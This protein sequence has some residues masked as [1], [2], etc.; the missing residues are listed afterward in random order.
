MRVLLAAAVLLGPAVALAQPDDR[1]PS[2]TPRVFESRGTIEV[3]LPDLERQPLSGFG[4]PPRTFVVPADRRPV[5][6]PFDPDL[7]ALPSLALAPIAEPDG[8]DRRQRR[9][10]VEAGG[11]AYASRYGRLDVSGTGASGEFFVEGAYDGIAGGDRVSDDEIRVRAGGQSYAPGRLRIEGTAL[12]DGYTTP[13]DFNPERRQ[14]RS[15]GVAVGIEGVGTAPYALT[16]G[17]EQGGLGR[18]D[19][20]EP[21]STEGR[22]DAEARLALVGDRIRADAAG[23]AAGSGGLGTEVRYGATGLA[24]SLGSDTGLQLTVGA[25]ALVLDVDGAASAADA[26]TAGPVVDLSLP[27]ASGAR[28]FAQNDPHVRVRS[29]TDL[30]GVNRFLTPDPLVVPDVVPV[31]ARAGLELR[32]GANRLRVF[33]LAFRAPTYLVFDRAGGQFS[34]GT[35]DVT[36]YGIGGDVT[37]AAPLGISASAGV[38]VRTADADGASAVPFFAPLTGRAGL[39]VPFDSGRGR[40]GLAA[41]AES[42]RPDDRTGSTDAPAW[43]RMSLDARYDLTGPFSAVLRAERLLGDAERWPGSPEPP[44]TVMLGLRFSR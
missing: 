38:E 26:Q 15:I 1:L 44:F 29:L 12:L 27:L 21:T 19:D 16:I 37:V 24:L 3:S 5:E 35:L 30:S 17:Y 8:D 41:L 9:L 23:G 28:V 31:D 42:P 25:R 11:G 20:S 4:P 43:G 14:R 36:A 7:D 40:L 10:R 34:T 32:P 13:A 6:K 22:I 39:Q 2:L 18:A 33:A